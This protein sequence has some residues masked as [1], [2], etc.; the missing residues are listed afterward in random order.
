VC[1]DGDCR[2]G[3]PIDCGDGNACTD[4]TCDPATGK[5][6]S[7]PAPDATP[8]DDGDLCTQGDACASGACAPG[9]PIIC[10]DQNPCTADSCDPTA[11]TCTL[12]DLPDST[13][14]D[15][16]SACTLEAQCLQGAC[17]VTAYLVCDDGDP[18]TQDACDP[19]KGCVTLPD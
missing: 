16:G 6:S 3:P 19:A 2:P 11:G 7:A 1:D 14:C 10:E 17:V 12:T 15:D 13:P 4:D 8:C 9:A 18:A 5:C